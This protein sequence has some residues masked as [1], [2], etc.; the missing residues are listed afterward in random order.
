[1]SE[2][3]SERIRANRFNIMVIETYN[4]VKNLT[5]EAEPDDKKGTTKGPCIC[6]S[7]M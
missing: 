5:P 6:L 1:M 7:S 2:E 3:V 4:R